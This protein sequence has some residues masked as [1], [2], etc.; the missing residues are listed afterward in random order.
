MGVRV[1]DIRISDE[2]RAG[3]NE[4]FLLGV[5]GEKVRFELDIEVEE[6]FFSLAEAEVDRIILNPNVTLTQTAFND[7]IIYCEDVVHVYL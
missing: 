6:C 2:F 3:E 4:P 1:T 5:I 7:N